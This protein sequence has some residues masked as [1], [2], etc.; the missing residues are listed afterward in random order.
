M[1][2]KGPTLIIKTTPIGLAVEGLDA[3]EDISLQLAIL[4]S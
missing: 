4:S 1:A 2:A 3:S